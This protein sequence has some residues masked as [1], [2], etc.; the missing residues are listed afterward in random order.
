MYSFFVI[1]GIIF[2]IFGWLFLYR[3][4]VILHMYAFF[5]NRVFNDM[6][7]LTEN[8]KIGALFILLSIIFLYLGLF[9]R[10]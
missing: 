4:K 10:H 3:R 1:F 2:L 5:R 7:V 6:H 9:I 8:R